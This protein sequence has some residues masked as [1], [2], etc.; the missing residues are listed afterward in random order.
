VTEA[1]VV[2]INLAD[3]PNDEEATKVREGCYDLFRKTPSDINEHLPTLRDLASGCAHVT[4]M[5]TRGGTSTMAFLAAQPAKLVC[6]DIDPMSIWRVLPWATKPFS[7]KTTFMPRV[8][9][10]LEVNIELTDL[11]FIDTLHTFAQLL[12]ELRT[13][14][15]DVK[16]YIALHDTETFGVTGE[17]GTSPGLRFAVEKFLDGSRSWEIAYDVR[18]NNGLMILKRKGLPA[19]SFNPTDPVK[20]S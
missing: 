6:Y 19:L 20:R 9:N 17:D 18:S 7:G 3:I 12:E 5:G 16:R 13:H 1:N 15:P 2:K 4:E 10:S 8:G 14:A 11:L